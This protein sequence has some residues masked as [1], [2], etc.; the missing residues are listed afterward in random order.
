MN[1]QDTV[2]YYFFDE[3]KFKKEVTAGNILEHTFV[4]GRGVYYGTYRLDL[5]KKLEEGRNIIVNP[6]VV[7]ARYYKKNY[8]A[9]TIFIKT[10]SI[11]NLK[12]RLV[13]RDKNISEEELT[14]RLKAA[15]YE[16]EH[17]EDFYDYVVVNADNKLEEAVNQVAE[18]LE[19]EMYRL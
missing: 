6:D 16:L 8:N 5:E 14:Q 3:Q 12:E 11:E 7:G 10:P 13:S 15:A 1:E 2:D 18:I 17:E 9:T 4:P 19:K